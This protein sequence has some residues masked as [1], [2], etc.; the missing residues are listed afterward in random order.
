[1][2]AIGTARRLAAFLAGEGEFQHPG[3]FDGV[4]KAFE[5]SPGG[6]AA[7]VRDGRS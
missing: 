6:R 4:F 7:P 2:P 1:M 5:G 3:E